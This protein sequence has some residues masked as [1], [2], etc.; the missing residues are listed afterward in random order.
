MIKIQTKQVIEV[1]D[2]DELVTKI[3]GRPYSFQQ[4]DGCKDRGIVNITV[5]DS[6]EDYDYENDSIPEVVNGDEI[7][8]KFEILALDYG[9]TKA[10]IQDKKLN[11]YNDADLQAAWIFWRESY[12]R[13]VKPLEHIWNST[14]DSLPDLY[15]DVFI[16]HRG[17]LEIAHLDEEVPSWEETFQ[18]FK[19]WADDGYTEF[20]WLD[21][22]H[23]R[24]IDIELPK[25]INGEVI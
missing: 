16:I 10:N 1:R 25:D 9:Y 4:Q 23:W 6:A 13:L 2:L 24:E 14:L 12:L 3:Y 15:K 7:R 20:D 19:Y 22:T 21:V 11:G 18:R 8:D 5:P 17:K